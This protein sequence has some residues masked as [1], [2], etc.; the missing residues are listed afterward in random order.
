MTAEIQPLK[1]IK[2]NDMK[3]HL[4]PILLTVAM[5]PASLLAQ[6]TTSTGTPTG[7]SLEANPHQ[8]QMEAAIFG[9]FQ[10]V[11][12]LDP[13]RY[14]NTFAPDG[15]LEDPGGSTP[16]HG[17]AAIAATYA[18]GLT[19]LGRITPRVKEIYVGVGNSTEATVSWILMAY[20]KQGKKVF[21][22]GIGIFKF[23]PIQAGSDLLLESVREFYDPLE[24]TSQ[25]Q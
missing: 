18:G 10:A 22:N 14:A 9:Y 25:L 2:G 20:T 8:K 17:R 19:I 13:Q 24:F 11:Q 16:V 21:V 4:L 7:P 12:S 6:P 15:T 5:I 3:T 23:K 1:P